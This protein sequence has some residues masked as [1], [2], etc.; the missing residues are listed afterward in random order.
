MPGTAKKIIVCSARLTI[1]AEV[2]YATA[3][4]LG[5]PARLKKG[6][7]FVLIDVGLEL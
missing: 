3:H 2:A 6:V 4:A 5:G 1:M 7:V